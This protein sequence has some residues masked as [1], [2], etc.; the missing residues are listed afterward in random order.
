MNFPFHII[1][2]YSLHYHQYVQLHYVFLLELTASSR[3]L[4]DDAKYIREFYSSH[5]E[6]LLAARTRTVNGLFFQS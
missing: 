6:L 4:G 1:Y 3:Y 2:L 5:F